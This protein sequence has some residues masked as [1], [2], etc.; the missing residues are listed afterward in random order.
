MKNKLFIAALSVILALFSGCKDENLK[1]KVTDSTESVIRSPDLYEDD[2]T[3]LIY[4]CGSSLESK[5]GAASDDISELL[6]AD[7]PHNVNVILETGGSTSWKK[8]GISAGKLQRYRMCEN[9]ME[10]LEENELSSMGDSST[11]REFIDWGTEKFPAKKTS[12]IL[13]DHGGGFLEG[14]CKDE[15]YGGD[16]LTVDE[17]D[18][19]LKSCSYPYSFDFI[20]FDA[21]YMSSYETALIA[22]KYCDYMIASENKEPAGGWDYR[23]IANS[24]GSGNEIAALLNSFS[25]EYSKKEEFS[26]TVLN[27][28]ELDTVKAAF[29]DC[30]DKGK[31]RFEEAISEAS[32][33]GYFSYGIYDMGDFA[34]LLGI[35]ADFSDCITVA[36]SDNMSDLSGI[37]FCFPME[38]SKLMADYIE[39]SADDYYTAFLR[40]NYSVCASKIPTI[41]AS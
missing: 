36:A 34:R 3:L 22:A 2:Y 12:L 41:T 16:W 17:F 20:G 18:N 8:H 11:L 14:I 23:A 24:L 32:S 29:K 7:I 15:I 1:E 19:A 39:K 25:E 27:L 35:E 5:N 37:S 26:L 33:I 31:T 30:I 9:K 10:L 38:D 40:Y 13:W 21:C 6:A 4:I 28:S